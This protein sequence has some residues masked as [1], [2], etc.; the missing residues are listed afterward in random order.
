MKWLRENTDEPDHIV[1][2][3]NA[4][5][6]AHQI[7]LSLYK[8]ASQDSPFP[9]ASVI[10]LEPMDWC[11]NWHWKPECTR[12]KPALG[13]RAACDLTDML[14][15]NPHVYGVLV[16]MNV[17]LSPMNCAIHCIYFARQIVANQ[18]LFTEFHKNLQNGRPMHPF[19]CK[20]DGAVAVC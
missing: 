18:A 17:Q 1:G 19:A 15:E 8:E 9:K 12:E 14:A 6:A 11:S 5:N 16:P 7:T 3:M 10:A 13:Y 20:G 2:I 4:G